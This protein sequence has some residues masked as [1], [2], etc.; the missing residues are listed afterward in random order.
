MPIH[1][2]FPTVILTETI[3]RAFTK[4]EMDFCI[5][6]QYRVDQSTSF[7]S[8]HSISLTID[9]AV[10]EKPEL[11]TVK[12][13]LMQQINHYMFEVMRVSD[14]VTFHISRS[15]FVKSLIGNYVRRHNHPNSILSGVLYFKT[16]KD[17]GNLMLYDDNSS[18]FG[19]M[20]FGYS[21]L[22][23]LNSSHVSIPPTEG[24][25]VMFPSRVLHEISVNQSY[26]PR[27]SLAFDVW[28][29][30]NMGGNTDVTKLSL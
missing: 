27:Y 25:L 22:T 2:L 19:S 21:S 4:D 14:E 28:V 1:Q 23:P 8:P 18:M 20:Q 3:G 13:F 29:T 5:N 30:G 26:E 16:S 7:E 11:A 24:N 10:L 6:N 12:E 9:H 15:W 17:C